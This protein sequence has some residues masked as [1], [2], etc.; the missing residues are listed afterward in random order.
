VLLHTGER[1]LDELTHRY[2]RTGYLASSCKLMKKLLDLDAVGAARVHLA[3]TW[4]FYFEGERFFE[5]TRSLFTA[6]ASRS[7]CSTPTGCWVASATRA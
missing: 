1:L 4:S 2:I 3:T 7:P 6:G 5:G